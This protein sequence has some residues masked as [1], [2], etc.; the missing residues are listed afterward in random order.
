VNQIFVGLFAIVSIAAGVAA[1]WRVVKTPG[2]GY[3]PLWIAGSLF[4]FVGVATPWSAQG[5]LYLQ[6]GIQIPVILILA[7][8]GGGTILKAMF[9]LVAAAALIRCEYV[10]APDR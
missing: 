4:G 3:K 7:F 8:P 2:L 1:I 9:P 6:F 5:D 10:K